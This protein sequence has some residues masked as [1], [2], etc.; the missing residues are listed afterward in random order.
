MAQCRMKSITRRRVRRRPNAR[1][2]VVERWLTGRGTA[3]LASA[4]ST[5]SVKLVGRWLSGQRRFAIGAIAFAYHRPR[6][7]P[8]ATARRPRGRGGRPGARAVT[9]MAAARVAAT[10]V[11]LIA[12]R[13]RSYPTD[14]VGVLDITALRSLTS[15][16]DC[17]GFRR[18]ADSLH[19]SQSAVSQHVRRLEQVCGRRL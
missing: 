9:R 18:A 1:E 6:A 19:L 14:M 13:I 2:E 5:I 10:G 17:G 3:R 11:P 8:G 12:K 7:H 4:I 16:A 15:I